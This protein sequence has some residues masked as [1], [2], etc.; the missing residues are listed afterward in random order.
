M[1]DDDF[2]PIILIL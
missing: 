1:N 2:P